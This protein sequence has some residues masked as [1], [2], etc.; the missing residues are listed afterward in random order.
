MILASFHA[1]TSLDDAIV[2]S[3]LL[4][5]PLSIKVSQIEIKMDL[6][7]I[8]PYLYVIYAGRQPK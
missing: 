7:R 6:E 8:D 1:G 2:I 3:A 5:I 4:I